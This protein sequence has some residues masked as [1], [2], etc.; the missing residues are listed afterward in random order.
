M[1]DLNT[2]QPKPLNLSKLLTVLRAAGLPIS[3]V[4]WAEDGS[5][6]YHWQTYPTDAQ[7]NLA[8]NIIAAHNPAADTEEAKRIQS[9]VLGFS[10]EKRL[11]SAETSIKDI[12]TKG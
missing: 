3:F 6:H 9:E 4:G 2:W 11:E 10:I 7:R 5:V 8:A 1:T 12:T